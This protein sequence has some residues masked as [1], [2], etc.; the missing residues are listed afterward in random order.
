LILR[1]SKTEKNHKNAEVRDT[2]GTRS[3]LLGFVFHFWLG[4]TAQLLVVI[5][6]R[7]VEFAFK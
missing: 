2:A 5:K 3:Q 7:E 1:S 6:R 4:V